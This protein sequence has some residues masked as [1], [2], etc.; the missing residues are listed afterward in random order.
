MQESDSLDELDRALVHALQIAPRASWAR[1]GAVLDIDPVTAARR[2][3]RLAARG[4]AWVSCYPGPGLS[5]TGRG[6]LAFVE[7]GC[8]NGRLL[9]VAG[10][11]GELPFVSTVEHVTGER[12]LLLTVMR[13]DLAAL[14]HWIT[15][16]L[17]SMEGITARRVELA[18]TVYTEGSR[19]RLRALSP[20]QVARL[21]DTGQV[22]EESAVFEPSVLDRRLLVALSADGRASFTRLAEQCDSSPDTVR[23][24]VA[25]LFA[26]RMV[27]AR[28]EVAR[29]LSEW[30]V[31]VIVR[32][33]V[34]PSALAEAARTV[35]GMREVRLCAGV[36]GRHNLLII[37]WVRSAV[38][39]QRLEARLIDRLPGIVIGNRAIALR[40]T[41][42]SGHLLDRYGHR[43]GTVPINP[44]AD[45]QP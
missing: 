16:G 20:G 39:A 32:A 1:I 40:P 27:Q 15:T 7:V 26:A 30:P 44:W 6:C 12:D 41:K 8:A 18:S 35:S 31:T 43:R 38:D 23:R 11:L 42:L 25:R 36:T 17:G 14:S 45:P 9:E 37:A 21:T 2:W 19:W 34:S 33:Q 29:R 13:P 10:R 22:P 28:C 3:N 4:A 5:A 24:R